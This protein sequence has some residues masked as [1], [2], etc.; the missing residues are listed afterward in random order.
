MAF[1][2]NRVSMKRIQNWIPAILMMGIIFWFSSQSADKL[3]VFSWADAIVKKSGHVVGYAL[4][5][6]SY[7]YALDIDKNK[8][9]V[10]WLFVILY[11]LTDEFHQSY[12]PGRHP[13]ILDVLIFDNFG[14]L[15]SLWLANKFTKQKRSGKN[16]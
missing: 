5:A 4:L 15:I 10:A 6:Y 13:S 2:L 16:T 11:A 1:T 12:V 8:R 14:A 7:W 9:W 3:P